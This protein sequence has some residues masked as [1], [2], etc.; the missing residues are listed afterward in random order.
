[1]KRHTVKQVARL[2]GISVRTLHFY[3]EIGLLKPAYYGENGYRYYEK[4]QLLILQQIL[5]YRELDVPLEQIKLILTDP[6]FNR[7]ETLRAHR[8]R[9][10]SELGRHQQLIRT[11]D[12]TIAELNGTET[13]AIEHMFEGFSS[14]KQR[15]YEKE[16]VATHGEN[17]QPKIDASK[18][19]IKGWTK[20]D[21][22]AASDRWQAFLQ[23][24]A[25]LERAG[26]AADSVEVQAL[27]PSHRAW[28]E[29]YWAPNREAYIGLG[30]LY[31]THP[32]FRK[33]FDAIREGLAEFCAEAM[34][35]YAEAELA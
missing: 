4:E 29:S 7:L 9:L 23:A 34:R 5:F 16:L 25:D 31:A 10:E 27:V 28:L 8:R 19:R 35:V 30:Q 20:E 2:S 18:E 33:Q 22:E 21:F 32:D 1:M 3:D 14:E 24:L 13:M 11:I 12:G 6:D 17:M 15:Q 26:N